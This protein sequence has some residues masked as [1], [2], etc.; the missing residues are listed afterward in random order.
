MQFVHIL[1]GDLKYVI[2]FVA[3]LCVGAYTLTTHTTLM[4]VETDD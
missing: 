4:E 1:S 2:G 3:L